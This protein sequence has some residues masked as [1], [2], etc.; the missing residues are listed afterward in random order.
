MKNGKVLQAKRVGLT[1]L[2]FISLFIFFVC[3]I[4]GNYGQVFLAQAED[5]S[6]DNA[7]NENIQ[8]QIEHLDLDALQEYL[9]KQ[10]K[11]QLFR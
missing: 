6:A 7:L 2:F 9:K 11:T 3:G 5:L 10:L 8:D 4:C 1:V